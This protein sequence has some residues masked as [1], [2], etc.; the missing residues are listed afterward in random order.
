MPQSLSTFALLLLQHEQR[1]AA[2]VTEPVLVWSIPRNSVDEG[3]GNEPIFGTMTSAMS[4]RRPREGEAMYFPIRKEPGSRNPFV[5]GV[6]LGR[7][8]NNDVL[9]PDGSISRFHAYFQQDARTAI[10]NVVD[11]DSKNGTWLGPLKLRPTAPYPVPDGS[12]LRFGDV[13]MV[14][15]MPASFVAYVK[16]QLGSEEG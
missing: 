15:W 8:E 11:A 5:M 13:E 3:E 1:A 14:F 9:V 10:W 4:H 7:A 6:T 2:S 16:Q 12:R